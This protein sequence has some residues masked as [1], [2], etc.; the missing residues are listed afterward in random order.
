MS[1]NIPTLLY[2][3][4]ENFKFTKLFN[5]YQKELK[6]NYILHETP[7][8]ISNFI[9]ANFNNIEEWWYDSN[10]QYIRKELINNFYYTSDK[11][12]EIWRNAIRN[13]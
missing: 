6:K 1:R 7:S 4:R 2:F 10:T 13:L 8:S 3:D 12:L 5:P 11:W 9:N